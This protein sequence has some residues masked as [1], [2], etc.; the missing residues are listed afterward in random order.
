MT[1]PQLIEAYYDTAE[2]SEEEVIESIDTLFE[3]SMSLDK[4]TFARHNITQDDAEAIALSNQYFIPDYFE[5]HKMPI[6][7]ITPIIAEHSTDLANSLAVSEP[8]TATQLLDELLYWREQ[9]RI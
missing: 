9:G 6:E 1:L 4:A 5:H 7:L 8:T 2:L 3:L